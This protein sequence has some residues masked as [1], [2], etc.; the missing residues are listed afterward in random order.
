MEEREIIAFEI[1]TKKWK[2][3]E[4]EGFTVQ[5][6]YEKLGDKV[7]KEIPYVGALAYLLR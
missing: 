3:A 6:M 4:D 2:W 7:F 1:N 5:E